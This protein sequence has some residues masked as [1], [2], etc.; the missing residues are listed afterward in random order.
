[1]CAHMY[2]H[3][4]CPP[5]PLPTHTHLSWSTVWRWSGGQSGQSR[6]PRGHWTLPLSVRPPTAAGSH[7]V[8]AINHASLPHVTLSLSNA[9]R[10]SPCLCKKP[11][12]FAP[13]YL[14]VCRSKVLFC[15][16]LPYVSNSYGKLC[17]GNVIYILHSIVIHTWNF[18]RVVFVSDQ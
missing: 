4:P 9:C 8:S 13:R 11:H 1:M 3:R 10:K 16:A 15:P 18:P 12:S 5:P 17:N 6:R 2:T 7:R 14:I